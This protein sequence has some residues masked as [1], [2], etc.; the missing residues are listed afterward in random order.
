[1]DTLAKRFLPR[2]V[3]TAVTKALQQVG[4]ARPNPNASQPGQ[5]PNPAGSRGPD[6]G[7]VRRNNSGSGVD[8][9]RNTP[10]FCA[11]RDPDLRPQLSS[12]QP[13]SALRGG[14]KFERTSLRN[15]T[16]RTT[17]SNS[18]PKE[19]TSP[20]DRGDWTMRPSGRQRDRPAARQPF[21]TTSI[22]PRRA[23]PSLRN[24]NRN[25]GRTRR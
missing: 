2:L 7:K 15:V 9:R 25:G 14:R 3:E 8:R 17:S 6:F 16:F 19:P 4:E 21:G 1:M 24:R 11:S 5:G 10:R 18:S 13:R 20:Y 22:T 23:I 12:Q